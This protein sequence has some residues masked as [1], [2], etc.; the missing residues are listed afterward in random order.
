MSKPPNVIFILSDQHNAKCLGHKG[1]PNVKTPNLDKLAAEGVRFDNAITQNPIC[2]PSRVCFHSGQYCHNHGCYGLSGPRPRGLPTMFGH[3]R[4]HGYT[5]AA[6]GKIHCPEYWIEDDCDVFHETC[7][8]SIDGRSA[9]YASYLEERGLTELED[10]GA[11][12]EF[13]PKGR[14]TV[15]GRPSKVSY[16]DGQEGW[17]AVKAIEFM[18]RAQSCNKPFFM[19][20][21]LP[22][23][24]QC[25]TPAEEFWNLYNEKDLVLPDNADSEDPH[26]PPHLKGMRER[27]RKADWTLFEPGTFTAGRLRKLHGYFGSISHV[28]H[29]VG[30]IVQWLDENGLGDETLVIY[31]SDHGDYAVEHGIMEKAPGICHDAITRIPYIWRWPGRFKPGHAAPELVETVDV[32]ATLTRLCGLPD[33]ETSDGRDISGLL[34]GGSGE[35]REVAVTEFAWSKSIRK[36]DWRMVWYPK[37]MFAEEYPDGFGQLYNLKEDPWEMKNLYFE[38]EHAGRVKEMRADLL[39][40]LV[41]NTRPATTLGPSVPESEQTITRYHHTVNADY[42]FNPGLIRQSTHANYL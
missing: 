10:H 17:I 30:E 23:P 24:H 19:H 25:Y 9:E 37:E 26:S 13:G 32:S 35:L 8:C 39:E 3:F 22:K 41:T 20:V 28:D 4:K 6:L 2:T 27:F 40:W 5:T 7:K 14:Q 29:A 1:H 21:S 33:L 36:G 34:E 11:M 12:N 38:S 42:R 15:E 16:Q 31:S 18:K